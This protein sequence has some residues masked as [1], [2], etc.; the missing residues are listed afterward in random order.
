MVV[1]FRQHDHRR[2]LGV[3]R[4]RDTAGLPQLQ[5]QYR[6]SDEDEDESDEHAA[7]N[8]HDEC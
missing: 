4:R 8:E 5:Q 3:R 2:R 6:S 1:I 7:S